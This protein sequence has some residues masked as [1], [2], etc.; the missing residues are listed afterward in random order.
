MENLAKALEGKK[1]KDLKKVNVANVSNL[2]EPTQ[3]EIE[4]I[5]AALKD[6]KSYKEIKKEIRREV[7]AGKQGF[8]Y[9]QIGE[10]DKA[11]EKKVAE[12]TPKVEPEGI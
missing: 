2:I 10:I 9:A 12:L 8:S 6:G 7:G 5:I 4:L 1:L 3:A 11:R